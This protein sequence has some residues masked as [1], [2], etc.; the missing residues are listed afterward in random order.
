MWRS[1]GFF[2]FSIVR[3]FLICCGYKGRGYLIRVVVFGDE[4]FGKFF[5]IVIYFFEEKEDKI[6][7]RMCNFW[8]FIE[9]GNVRVNGE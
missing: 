7:S 5:W 8:F 2:V 4:F 6:I 1:M 3:S 9:F